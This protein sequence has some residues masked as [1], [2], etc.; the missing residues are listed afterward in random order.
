MIRSLAG[1]DD[2]QVIAAKI[3]L[4]LAT[5][6]LYACHAGI[7]LNTKHTHVYPEIDP[8]V[9]ALLAT[10]ARRREMTVDQLAS[11]ILTRVVSDDLYLTILGDDLDG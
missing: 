4:S 3:G 1:H 2:P 10:E 9:R 6:R 7:S 5:V 11:D 8:L